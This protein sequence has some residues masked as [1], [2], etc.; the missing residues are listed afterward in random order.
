MILFNIMKYNEFMGQVKR[1]YRS[2]LRAE[3]TEA[4]RRRIIDAARRL[5][6]GQRYEGVT[7]EQLAEEAG[8]AIQTL[9]AAFGSKFNLACAVVQEA[10]G[11]AGVPEMAQTAAAMADAE[12]ML[13]YLAHVNRV[14][15]ER[16][17][18]LDNILSAHS[19]REVAETS[20]QAR[21]RDLAGIAEQLFA[22]PQRRADLS[23]KDVSDILVTLTAPLLYRMLVV[24]RGWPPER[25][26]HWLGDL[27]VGALLH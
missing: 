11:S 27:L 19:M 18:D 10:L 14:V 25:Y 9:Y 15:D 22:A 2:K 1:V 16:L 7:M 21:E 13:R 12:E 26:E 24:E 8:V 20:A 6:A 17:L 3:Q 5:F 4:T 23:L